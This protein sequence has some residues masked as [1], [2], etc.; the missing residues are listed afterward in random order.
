[1]QTKSSHLPNWICKIKQI[2]KLFV[3]QNGSGLIIRVSMNKIQKNILLEI[4]AGNV[5]QHKTKR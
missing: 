1:M 2:A 4:E 5:Y 3:F